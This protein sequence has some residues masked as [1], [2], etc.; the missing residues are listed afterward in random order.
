MAHNVLQFAAPALSGCPGGRRRAPSRRR[1]NCHVMQSA[2]DR[3]AV[4]PGFPLPRFPSE[5]GSPP[6]STLHAICG[7]PRSASP[8]VRALRRANS[9]EIEGGSEPASA[10]SLLFPPERAFGI[11]FQGLPNLESPS[12]AV[13]CTAR[14]GP[15][16]LD[17]GPRERPGAGNAAVIRR[18]APFRIRRRTQP[19]ARRRIDHPV[20]RQPSPPPR[21]KERLLDVRPLLVPRPPGER[22]QR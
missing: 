11:T 22:R 12:R 4:L 16:G 13:L 15:K 5:K 8:G 7:G 18:W 10:E 19:L 9:A 2:S 20:R 21:S 1:A 3:A 17:E 14:D 6:N